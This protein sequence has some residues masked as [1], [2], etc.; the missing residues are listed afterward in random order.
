[1]YKSIQ[2]LNQSIWPAKKLS[3]AH[4]LATSPHHLHPDSGS[5]AASAWTFERVHILF[6]LFLE[7]GLIKLPKVQAQPKDGEN[8]AMLVKNTV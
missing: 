8:C 4:A 2:H 7:F 5:G 3:T 1:M 6:F